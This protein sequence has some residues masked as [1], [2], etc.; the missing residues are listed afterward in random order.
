MYNQIAGN[1]AQS[2]Y[3]LKAQAAYQQQAGINAVVAPPRTIAS[4]ISRMEGLNERLAKVNS[5]LSGIANELG[6]LRQAGSNGI[7]KAPCVGAIGRLNDSADAAH[8]QLA[9]IEDL[10]SAISTAL[11]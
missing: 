10:L 9:D 8:S 5:H 4:A 7:E 6:A 11:G 2:E 1:F 3:A